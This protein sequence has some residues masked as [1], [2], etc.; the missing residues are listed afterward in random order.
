MT[1]TSQ[2]GQ[3]ANTIKLSAVNANASQQNSRH[4]LRV[5]ENLSKHKQ[6]LSKARL[7]LKDIN[8]GVVISD[9]G[10]TDA[11]KELLTKVSPDSDLLITSLQNKAANS[12]AALIKNLLES[13]FGAN[14]SAMLNPGL[15][16]DEIRDQFKTQPKLL[17]FFH[18]LPGLIFLIKDYNAGELTKKQFTTQ[19]W[20]TF[21]HNGPQK[22]FSNNFVEGLNKDREKQGLVLHL[23][24]PFANEV[25]EFI[26]LNPREEALLHTTY[27][28]LDQAQD[29]LAKIAI[30]VSKFQDLKDVN[31]N[32]L[33][34]NAPWTIEQLDAL[35]LLADKAM[36]SRPELGFI[37][38]AIDTAKSTI[39]R[40]MKFVQAGLSWDESGDKQTLSFKHPDGTIEA[41]HKRGNDDYE[42]T[43]TTSKPAN[44]EEF[45]AKN[46]SQ[47]LSRVVRNF[48]EEDRYIQ[49]A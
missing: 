9:Y 17:G 42:H 20:S 4:Q 32:L 46:A 19:F 5:L 16:A 36:E 11:G 29:G 38:Q 27:D 21:A 49:A 2:I 41:L 31:G 15:S 37:G 6:E 25:G 34:T 13:K 47:F 10:K 18:E 28:R 22:G 7:N 33:G 43:I 1:Y 30:E 3:Y 40:F 26:Y 35:K 12:S 48:K 24:T 23:G 45:M 44:R 14:Y 8:S 39:Q